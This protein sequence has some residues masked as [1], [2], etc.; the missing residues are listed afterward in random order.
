[1]RLTT[2]LHLMPSLTV[3]EVR[4]RYHMDKSTLTTNRH[5]PNN[6]GGNSC[7]VDYLVRTNVK[8][9]QYNSDTLDFAVLV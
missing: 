2:H 4:L 8:G 6:I 1:M 7:L 9:F 3:S 5:A